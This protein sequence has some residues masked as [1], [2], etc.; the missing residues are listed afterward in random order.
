MIGRSLGLLACVWASMGCV[1]QE[2]TAGLD[3]ENSKRTTLSSWGN[4]AP[5]LTAVIPSGF[6]M[7]K[8]NGPDFDVHRIRH[9]DDIGVLSIYVGHHPNRSSAPEPLKI[10]RKVG[11]RI[12][13]FEKKSTIYGSFADALVGGFLSGAEISGVNELVLH[14]F[15][16]AK[17][18]RFYDDAWKILATLS[19]TPKKNDED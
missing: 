5:G 1:Q 18:E 7:E 2:P 4:G 15:I 9:P 11:S 14:I 19:T 17:E 13:T 16:A 6:I 10:R 8:T 3:A 12:V